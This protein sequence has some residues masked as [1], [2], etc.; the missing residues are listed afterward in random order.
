M[1]VQGHV[2]NTVIAQYFETGRVMMFRQSDLRFG[3]QGVI[4]VLAHTEISFLRELHWPASIEIGTGVAEVGR[5]SY[6][7]VHGVFRGEHCIAFGRA[8]LVMID[9]ETRRATPLAEDFIARL[10]DWTYRGE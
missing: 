2:N 5:S 3:G 6:T 4:V 9:R 7:L 8:T 10:A 1:D